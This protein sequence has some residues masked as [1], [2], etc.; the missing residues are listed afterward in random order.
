MYYKKLV[1]LMMRKFLPPFHPWKYRWIAYMYG[2]QHGGYFNEETKY[3]ATLNENEEHIKNKAIKN[4][5]N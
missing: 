5:L 3:T 1:L 4:G 2:P